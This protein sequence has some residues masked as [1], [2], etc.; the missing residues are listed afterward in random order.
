MLSPTISGRKVAVWLR[1][2]SLVKLRTS[3]PDEIVDDLAMIVS[4]YVRGH[5]CVFGCVRIRIVC[6]Q[7]RVCP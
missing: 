4:T 2:S 7:E 3:T 1:E 5:V 6:V